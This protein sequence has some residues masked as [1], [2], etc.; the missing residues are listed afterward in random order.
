MINEKELKQYQKDGFVLKKNLIDPYVIEQLRVDAAEIFS[1]QMQAAG[2]D[3]S[4]RWPRRYPGFDKR[5][6]KF[7]ESHFDQ[8]VNCGK[9]I[10]HLIS[11]HKLGVDDNILQCVKDLGITFPNIC[12]RPVL[13][14]NHRRLATE[15]VYHTVPP[16]QDWSS[17]QGS[18]D[19]VVVWLPLTKVYRQIGALKVVPGSHKAGLQAVKEYKS[20]G[21]VDPDKDY[22]FIDVEA[23]PGD[24][25][26]FSSF[27][28]HRSG[29]NITEKIRWSC[30]FR[31]NNMQDTDFIGRGYPHP[32]LYKVKEC[33]LKNE[34]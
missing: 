20:F 33:A 29:V 9:H 32:Y 2:Y 28:I 34:G 11:L 26:F 27:L 1:L 13:F 15:D 16:H 12:T 7:F 10:Q 30:H 25:L 31:Y 22:N 21:I 8:F 6:F 19:A 23:D 4:K 18:K 3:E 5:L 14:F 24:A 17:M